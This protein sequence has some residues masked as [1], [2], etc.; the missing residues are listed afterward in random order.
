MGGSQI[1]IETD[2]MARRIDDLQTEVERLR[3]N[4][5]IEVN[6]LSRELREKKSRLNRLLEQL[7]HLPRYAQ[8]IQEKCEQYWNE[9]NVLDAEYH[10]ALQMIHEDAQRIS[11]AI[12]EARGED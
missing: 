7:E 5:S 3:E 8:N 9:D 12:A 2:V 11:Y 1:Q 10:A 4:W 6:E